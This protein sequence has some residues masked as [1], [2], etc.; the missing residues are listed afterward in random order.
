MS[1]S[2]SPMKND[3]SSAPVVNRDD[4][5]V[6]SEKEKTTLRISKEIESLDEIINILKKQ[7]DH[8]KIS[9]TLGIF[10]L[11]FTPAFIQVYNDISAGKADGVTQAFLAA[12]ILGII[13]LAYALIRERD[14]CLNIQRLEQEVA[15]K[16]RELRIFIT[17]KL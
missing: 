6:K 2:L 16:E 8:D 13:M 15:H 10:G 9:W 12:G 7:K 1:A 5:S 17:G 3:T 4:D 14:K 11:L